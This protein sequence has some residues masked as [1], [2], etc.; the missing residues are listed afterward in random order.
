VSVVNAYTVDL[1][2]WYQGL[3]STNREPERWP[4]YEARLA[5]STARLLALLGKYSVRATFFVLGPVAEQYPDLV[6]Q[7]DAAGHELG[8][9]GYWHERVHRLTPERLAADLD[10]VVQA[11]SPLASHPIVGHRAPYFSI[12]GQT[13]W[14]LDV[15]RERGFRYD[16]S[17]FPTRNMLYGY[18]DAPRFPCRVGHRGGLVEFPISTARWL[19]VTW[20]MGGGFYVRALPY[21]VIRAGIQQLNR[22]GQPA[23]LYVHPWELDTGQNYRKVTFRERVSHYYG[24]QGLEKKLSRLLEEFSFSPLQELVDGV[25]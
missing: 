17:F 13:L 2:D 3:T 9:H 22:Q 7:I 11:L 19:G 10:R 4:A 23:I 25:V 20:P 8:V 1:E 14:A 6:R 24:R 12:N 18:P 21:G 5:N 16:S 15:L